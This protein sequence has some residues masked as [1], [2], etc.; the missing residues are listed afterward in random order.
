Y[1]DTRPTFASFACPLRHEAAA[2]LPLRLLFPLQPRTLDA[3]QACSSDMKVGLLK[4]EVL[5]H[6]KGGLGKPMFLLGFYRGS[7]A[8]LSTMPFDEYKEKNEIEDDN[9]IDDKKELEPQGVDP[10]KGWGFRGV[11]KAIICGKIGQAPVQKILRNGKTV[12]IFTVGTGGMYDQRITGAEHLP[13]PA[14]WHRIAVHNEWLGAYSVQ[15]LEKNS[16]VF[17]EGD[18]E[19]RVYNDSI[20]GQVKNIPEI[21]VRHDGKVRLIKS[22]DNAASMSLKGL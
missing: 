11:H 20:T 5:K 2:L 12:T 19:T 15:Q 9:F 10:I 4:W 16:A 18:I 1:F 17:I 8:C 22:G 6:L 13:R 7:Q 14:Q 21:C 3:K